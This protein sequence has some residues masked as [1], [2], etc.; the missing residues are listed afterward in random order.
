MH[1]ILKKKL[2]VTVKVISINIFSY[3]KDKN[4]TIVKC[5]TILIV[6]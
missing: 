5:F 3:K 2:F 6:I 4:K 1:L